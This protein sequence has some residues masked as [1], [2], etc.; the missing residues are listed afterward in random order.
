MK[1]TTKWLLAGGA[2]ATFSLLFMELAEARPGGGQ[3][4]S[5]GG[6]HGGGSSGD[7]GGGELLYII[8]RI[9]LELIIHKPAI[10]IPV[11]IIVIAIAIAVY[12]HAKHQ[13]RGLTDWDSGPPSIYK[14]PPPKLEKIRKIDDEFSTVLFEDFVY[15]LFAQA[16]QSR[17]VDGG[18]D[19]L[20]PYI[21]DKAR[22]TLALVE[23]TGVPVAG[24]I[25][26][27]MRPTGVNVP[28]KNPFQADGTP[29][30][31][32]I[33]LQFEACFTAG[34]PGNERGFFVVETWTLTR[35]AD[36]KSKPPGKA[37]DFPCPNCGAPFEQ[38][39]DQKCE[40]CGEVVDNGR[41]D[42]LVTAINRSHTAMGGPLLTGTVPER[43]TDLDTYMDADVGHEWGVLS[44]ED[45]ALNQDAIQARIFL[46]F[47]QLNKAWQELDLSAARPYVSDGMFDYLQYWV[48]AYKQQ[49]LR[50]KVDEAK[51]TQWTVCKVKRDK[52][53]DAMTCRVWATGKDYTIEDAS[54]KV[55]GGSKRNWRP[56]TEYWTLIR[57]AGTR[58][59][60]SGKKEC[61]KC[62]ADMK[63]NM[64]G[65][66]EYC[67]AHL[68][69]GEFDFV[70]SK[71][72]QDDSYRG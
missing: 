46:I 31:T 48:T 72:E 56:Y 40:Y 41:F 29:N 68:T 5:G 23:P 10:G 33:T 71:I 58:G 66:C 30:F 70:L 19:K 37:Q 43:G 54:G 8:F 4:Y 16:H 25:V 28:H 27:A 52:Y 63:I 69:S 49:G 47:E 42:W 15:K 22:G 60:P 18:L 38:T 11:T 32:H 26:G 57:N 51:I 9:L 55:V 50:N 59:E 39:A 3:S 44:S 14:G 13:K 61:P 35:A 1:R 21:S 6:G 12:V 53:Y 64:A 34:H 45:T 24:V 17:G 67:G 36:V 7:G 62:G 2:L 65:S 20:A